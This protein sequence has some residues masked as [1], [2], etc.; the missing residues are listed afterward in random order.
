MGGR[1]GQTYESDI[2]DELGARGGREV[3]TGAVLGGGLQAEEVD[4]RLLEELVAAELEGALEEVTGGRG[5]E[6]GQERAG[7]LLLDDL[8][9]AADHALV[10]GGRVELDPRLDAGMG[11]SEHVQRL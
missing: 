2:S 6:T 8:A 9:E 11:V 4:V 3:D 7:A 5:A 1:G 10:V